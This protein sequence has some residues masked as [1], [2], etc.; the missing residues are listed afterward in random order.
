MKDSKL[1]K[2]A[3]P[4]TGEEEAAAVREVILSGKFVSGLNVTA[5]ES[6][7]ASYIGVSEAAAV[8]SGTAAL[9]LALAVLGIGPGDEVIVPSLTFMSTVTSVFHQ[10][11]VP[12]FADIDKDSFCISPDDI[13]KKITKRTR[14]I[15]P[16]HLYGNAADMDKIMQIADKRNLYVIEDCAQAHGTEY[17]GKRVGGIGDI[18]AFSFFATKQMTTGEGGIIISNDK[19]W[20]DDAKQRR[21]HGMTGR[22]DHEVLGYNYRMNEMAAAM[23]LIQLKKLDELNQQRIENSLWL[24]RKLE[25]NP[26]EWFQTPKITDKIKHTF[27]WCP[28]KICSEQGYDTKDVVNRLR[29]KYVEV[30]HRY[31]QPLYKQKVIQDYSPYPNGCPYSCRPEDCGQDYR[32]LYL[33]N[34]EEIAGNIIG[35]PNHPALKTEQLEYIIETVLNLYG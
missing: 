20:I 2:V 35:L 14:A 13:K 8:N 34:V 21:S 3:I 27:F 10:N 11:A 19:K 12:V 28:L 15:I 5:F 22:D 4:I 32:N 9:H 33:P 17:K 29:E 1:I 24:L 25:D 16:V 26:R 18:G 30:R 31:Y 7:F 6:E 23:G